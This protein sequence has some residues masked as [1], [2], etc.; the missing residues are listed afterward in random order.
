MAER[1][2]VQVLFVQQPVPTYHYDN[3][4]RAVPLRP[5]QMAPYVATAKAYP[6]L[7]ELRGTGKLWEH[8]LLWL[9]ELE[10]AS[11]NAY[12]DPV[13]YSPAFA[14]LIGETVAK[15]LAEMLPAPPPLPEPAPAAK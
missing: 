3:A 9:A 6:R 2:G 1:F 8:N 13:H 14:K 15:W 11:G 7:A 5:E 4:K 10:P 12:I